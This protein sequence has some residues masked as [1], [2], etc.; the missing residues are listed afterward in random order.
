MRPRR[1]EAREEDA[2]N[3][4]V[5]VGPLQ[6]TRFPGSEETRPLKRTLRSPGTRCVLFRDDR[7]ITRLD[8]EMERL[9]RKTKGLDRE[10]ERLARRIERAEGKITRLDGK[11]A[12]PEGRNWNRCGTWKIAEN[13]TFRTFLIGALWPIRNVPFLAL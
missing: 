10:I 3:A 8:R 9:H 5:S 1:R 4:A 7:K 11:N 13:G 12:R 2:K 6:R